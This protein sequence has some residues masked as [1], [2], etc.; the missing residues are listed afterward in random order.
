[1]PPAARLSLAETRKRLDALL[2]VEFSF[3]DTS[4]PAAAITALPAPEQT[5]LLSW[6]GRIAST[7]VE[8]GFQ[9]A[10]HGVEAQA[11]M[12][13]DDFEAWVF[14]AMD[15]YDAEGL[16]PALLVIKQYRQFAE[17][18]QARQRGA[19]LQDYEGVLSHFLHGLS[20]R[21]LKLGTADRPHT[22]SETLYLPP[23]LSQL[24][25]PEQNFQLYKVTCALLW[26]QI[27]FGSFRPLLALSSPAPDLLALYHALEMQRLEACLS[28]TLPGL[29]R[30]L[31]QLRGALTEPPLPAAWRQILPQLA[32][33]AL[34][35]EDVLLLAQQQLGRL[36]AG[37][38]GL[39]Q[40]TLELAA[41][42]SCMSARIKKEQARFKV[43]LNTLLEELQ[44][45]TSTTPAPERRFGKRRHEDP[46]APEGFHTEV[47]LD[48]LPVP[49]PDAVQALQR[50]ILLDLGDIP[51]D[52]LQ[53][54]GPGEYDPS[55][56][57]EQT[58]DAEDVWRGSY[59]EEGAHLYDEWD[60]Q[61]RHYRKNWCAVRER[62][63]TPLYDDFTARTLDKYHGLIKHLRKTFEAMRHD[64]RLLKRQ[65]EGDDV[66]ID[67]LV[68]ALS[69]AHL[70]FEMTDRLLTKMQR[71]ER[72]IAVV[73]MVD[74]S[75]ST[76]G[77][78]NDAERESL[79]LLCE[80]LESLGDR[81]AIYGFSGMT[82]KRCELFHIKHFDEPY[83]ALIRARIS[84]IEPQDYTRMGFAIRHLTRILQQTEAKT[85]L[86]V[87]LSDGKPDD[88]DSYRGE[89]GIE[90]TRRALIE[91]RRGGIHP[92]CI[93]IDEEARDYLPHLYG[94]AAYSV[95][96]D[97][98]TLPLK[99]ADIY[100]RLTS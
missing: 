60:F 79:L 7:H 53:P 89:Y 8:L 65:P 25:S 86:L 38:P 59:H 87:T 69:D 26:A 68:E 48:D 63:V 49:L 22:D 4:A 78:I 35:A 11:L 29:H 30:V 28:R 66:D 13:A 2:E 10:C 97:V 91:A 61:R 33:P 93:T 40:I 15:R 73:F 43:A 95:V 5:A 16:R 12:A 62:E 37:P 14:H 81:Y 1:M 52:Y 76:K 9:L 83:G 99:V 46:T 58:R 57:Q 47:L 3:R 88:Y 82:R 98:R 44:R 75:G 74:M 50:S 100:R 96:D 31:G 17:Q 36:P 55:L 41:V 80:A 32:A 64:N 67:A 18:Q 85:R 90:D 42:Q 6:I 94:P 23:L 34:R 51:D 19:L 45:P 54:A 20:G 92:Y 39:H 70:G 71:N 84:G 21:P 56:L 72:H 24:P 77:W 27:Q